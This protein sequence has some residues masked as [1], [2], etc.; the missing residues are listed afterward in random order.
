[1]LAINSLSWN[2]F[3][4]WDNLFFCSLESFYK[5]L[6]EFAEA[7]KLSTEVN[8]SNWSCSGP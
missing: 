8:S 2:F 6:T 1:M 4:S 3:E 5:M 7:L